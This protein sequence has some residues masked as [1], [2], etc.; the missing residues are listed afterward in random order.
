MSVH[1]VHII[2]N[3]EEYGEVE[4]KVVEVRLLI[5]NKHSLKC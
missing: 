5:V 4:C 2:H 1:S 3:F